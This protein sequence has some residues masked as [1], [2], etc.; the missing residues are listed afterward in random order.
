VGENLLLTSETGKGFH[1]LLAEMRGEITV[2]TL[3]DASGASR[4]YTLP[5]LE[6]FDAVGI[7][8]R[9]GDKRVLLR[10]PEA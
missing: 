4:K 6:H 10:R 1:R 3:R 9:V 5:I 2:A 7:T 8:R